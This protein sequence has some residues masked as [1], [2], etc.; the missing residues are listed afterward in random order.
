[1]LPGEPLPIEAQGR[2]PPLIEYGK[3][4]ILTWY[5]SP[6]PQ[7]YARYVYQIS[8]H[9][10]ALFVLLIVASFDFG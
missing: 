8:D 10:I 6:Y 3:Y 7:E 9:D 4:E 1:M 2:Y 5:S